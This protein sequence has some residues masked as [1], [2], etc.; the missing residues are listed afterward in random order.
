MNRPVVLLVSGCDDHDNTMRPA[1]FQGHL[2]FDLRRVE[3]G[4]VPFRGCPPERCRAVY[5]LA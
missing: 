4:H 3:D 1:L 5:R 2:S